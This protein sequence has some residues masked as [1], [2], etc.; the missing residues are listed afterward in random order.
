[1]VIRMFIISVF[2]SIEVKFV[3]QKLRIS[4]S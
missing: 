1:L 2:I 3:L 4:G